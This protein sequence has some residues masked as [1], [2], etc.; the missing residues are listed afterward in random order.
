MSETQSLHSTVL[1]ALAIEDFIEVRKDTQGCLLTECES[2]GEFMV[3]VEGKDLF[4][5][6]DTILPNVYCYRGS[7]WLLDVEGNAY[8]GVVLENSNVQYLV[9]IGDI[10]RNRGCSS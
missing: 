7:G 8:E 9:L 5:S 2:P 1:E 3:V 4:A 10:Y 6:T